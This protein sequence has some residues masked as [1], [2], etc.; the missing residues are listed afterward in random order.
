M[1]AGGW[2]AV[3]TYALTLAVWQGKDAFMLALDRVLPK[4]KPEP[5]EAEEEA[6]TCQKMN[7]C[8]K[9][10]SVRFK[11]DCCAEAAGILRE[12]P[13]CHTIPKLA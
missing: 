9:S 5:Y 1:S 4:K 8:E 7:S 11:R 3:T 6:S 2:P 13:L 12:R 10:V